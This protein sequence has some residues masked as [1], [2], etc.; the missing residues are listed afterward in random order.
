MG[1]LASASTGIKGLDEIV[2]NLRL[3]DN[4]VW[5]VD[6]ID[7]YQHFVDPY[8]K[9]SLRENRNLVYMRFAKHPPLI[10]PNATVKVYKL[11]AESGFETFTKQVHAIIEKEGI[12]TFYVF[13]C[14]SD[15]LSIWATDLMI[16]NFFMVTCPYLFKLETIAY[17][18]ILKDNHSFKTI[19]RIRETTQLLLDVFDFEDNFYVQPLKV[20]N[21]YSPTMF[22]PH[23]QEK[24]KFVPI[25]SSIDAARIF[26][27]ISKKGAESAE[28]NLDFWDRLFLDAEE[29]SRKPGEK[30]SKKEMLERLDRIML[31][32][33][34]R[35]LSLIKE[36]LTLEDLLAIKS[37]MVGTGFIGGKALGMLLARKIL[38]KDKS[39]DWE[40]MLEPHDSFYIGSDVFYT[41]IVENGWW[42]LWL[43]QKTEKGY[44][45]KA[46]ELKEKILTGK[47]PHETRE[48]F[49][50]I[51]EYFGQSPIIVRSS[52]LL[53][54]AFGN[55]F[56]G[57]YESIFDV[58]QGSPEE[59]Y[60]RFEDIIRHVYASTVN[61]DALNYR[62]QRGLS[63][64]DE[65]MALLVQ[66]VSGT[67]R[68][69]Y[70]FPFIA[71][72]GFSYNT[73][74]WHRD[75][76]P[77][78][79]MLRLVL[80]LGT[81]AVNRAEGDYPRIVALDKPLMRPYA[82]MEK[83]KKFSQH[84]VD[85]LNMDEND[86]QTI[87]LQKLLENEP[88]V[89][90]DLVGQRDLEAEIKMKELGMEG[91]SWV[92]TFDKLL[93]DTDFSKI[94]QRTL[95][96]LEEAYQYPVDVEF[97]V[98]FGRQGQSQVN[99]VQCRPLQAKGEAAQVKI[100]E[101]ISQ[102]K[103]VFKSEGNFM[104]G[105][106]SQAIKRLIYVDTEAYRELLMS[107]KF[108]VA[109]L[110]GRLNKQNKGV[111]ALLIGPG[112]WGSRDPSLGVPVN[113][114][115]INNVS[116]LVEVDDPAG[117][118]MPELSFGSHFFLDL[119]ET[120]IFYTAL[121]MDNENVFFNKGWLDGLRNRLGELIPEAEEYQHV[122]KVHD[123]KKELKLL[124]DVTTQKVVCL[125]GQ[126]KLG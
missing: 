30:K 118:F 97:T 82:G 112:R 79:G 107:K 105:S 45:T 44:F 51:I 35:M 96:T 22:L 50:L 102:D 84:D 115:E 42:D 52:S 108:E 16:G 13:D 49:R 23:I 86:L 10:P 15:L 46:A 62:L 104:G 63:Q 59:R 72:V 14:L 24:E 95:K 9:R 101:D 21:R 113:F 126:E 89:K 39:F 37:R 109:R 12:E 67:R 125:K 11:D 111:A 32:R 48:Q 58:N 90:L 92:L 76:N 70:F 78:A 4:V 33:E 77:K 121:F 71:G 73:F 36:H 120:N 28:R 80:G 123:F 116:A 40:K 41:Y 124:S 19:A 38:S 68:K 47:F 60:Q 27:Y 65:Q 31:G 91:Q 69:H 55:A 93:S 83:A 53:E 98:N 88:G 25:T 56:A 18:A 85:I 7:D 119:V 29:L 2:Q 5:Q 99:L 100:T 117:G 26:S 122:I 110:I 75:M 43:E 64:A 87:P 1:L 57:K 66:R 6:D 94:I 34:A 106:I 61:E 54:D 74:V 17:F 103:L 3:G 8:V 114:A 20:W 81:R